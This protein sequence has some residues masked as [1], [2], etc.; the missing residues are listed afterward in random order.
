[1]QSSIIIIITIITLSLLYV[2]IFMYILIVRT[3]EIIPLCYC[4]ILNFKSDTDLL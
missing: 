1:M 4:T 3:K 2:V